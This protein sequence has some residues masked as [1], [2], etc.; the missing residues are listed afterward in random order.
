M[1]QAPKQR[2]ISIAKAIR[3]LQEN[4]ARSGPVARAS[5]TLIGANMLLG[6]LGYFQDGR[7]RKQR[8]GF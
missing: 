7:L 6:R 4:L 1:V 2:G 5:Y 3:A 8:I